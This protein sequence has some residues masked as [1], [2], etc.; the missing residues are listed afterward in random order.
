VKDFAPALRVAEFRRWWLALLAM[1]I[2]MQM[3]EVAIA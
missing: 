3:L 1:G 2:G